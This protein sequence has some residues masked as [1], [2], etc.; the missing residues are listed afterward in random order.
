MHPARSSSSSFNVA[1]IFSREKASISRP[2]TRVYSPFAVVT[3]T[4]YITSCGMP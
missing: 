2:V 4:P 3:G 1:S